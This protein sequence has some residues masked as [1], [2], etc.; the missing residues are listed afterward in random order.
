MQNYIPV[1]P[2]PEQW[3]GLPEG[4][5]GLVVD[6]QVN[7]YTALLQLRR[8]FLGAGAF[9]VTGLG[10]A[11]TDSLRRLVDQV[12]LW[13]MKRDGDEFWLVEDKLKVVSVDT[14]DYSHENAFKVESV[15]QRHYSL[16]RR[17]RY[18]VTVSPTDVEK[19]RQWF[20]LVREGRNGADVALESALKPFAL[21]L[22][23]MWLKRGHGWDKMR[24]N[25]PHLVKETVTRVTPEEVEWD[26]IWFTGAR[27]GHQMRCALIQ[28]L[29]R[30][31]P[32]YKPKR[33]AVV[34]PETVTSQMEAQVSEEIS[35]TVA[36]GAAGGSFQRLVPLKP[37][38]SIHRVAPPRKSSA[39]RKRAQGPV[40][41]PAGFAGEGSWLKRTCTNQ[42]AGGLREFEYAAGGFAQEEE[43]KT[44]ICL[45]GSQGVA[46]EVGTPLY[47]SLVAAGSGWTT[48][49][50]EGT[51]GKVYGTFAQPMEVV[52][53]ERG[54]PV[55]SRAPAPGWLRCDEEV[56]QNPL[57]A[58]KLSQTGLDRFLDGLLEQPMG[59]ELPELAVTASG[60][61]YGLQE[62]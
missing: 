11:A 62:L 23:E 4:R 31:L 49:R 9:E 37:S 59:G 55:G 38:V 46:V 24:K 8:H 57:D 60:E 56:A 21:G 13:A 33:P 29:A 40:E 28:V 6:F 25:F 3:A 1:D 52:K 15:M 42:L 27:D 48:F 50:V 47:D 30:F 2:S 34:W 32:G 39:P 7:L 19:M 51:T 54:F 5:T 44:P 36:S 41:R 12:A 16:S 26:A 22:A 53:D 17:G 18:R 58:E 14:L 45:S 10:L 61:V 20:A 43:V 35:I